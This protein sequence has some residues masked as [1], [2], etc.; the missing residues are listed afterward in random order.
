MH[1]IFEQY[2]SEFN[3]RVS[4]FPPAF[5]PDELY[6]SLAALNPEIE[7]VIEEARDMVISLDPPADPSSHPTS[8]TKCRKNA[9]RPR[10]SG[11]TINRS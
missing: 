4:S 10:E 8:A 11:P 9:A 5:T 1:A 3:P 6:L 7:M 2:A